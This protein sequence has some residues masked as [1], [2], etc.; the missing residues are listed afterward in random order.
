MSAVVVS[1]K[2]HTVILTWMN[3]KKI[4]CTLDIDSRATSI[5]VWRDL[6]H[7]RRT[8][9]IAIGNDASCSLKDGAL[10]FVTSQGSFVIYR[11][12]EVKNV[13]VRIISFYKTIEIADL[14]AELQACKDEIATL[15]Q[16]NMADLD[17]LNQIANIARE[18]LIHSS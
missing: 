10:T 17:M 13:V 4:I 12:E 1:Q 6:L 11:Y 9:E 14:R 2:D 5:E 16:S 8:C 18:L 7:G 15:R 3:G